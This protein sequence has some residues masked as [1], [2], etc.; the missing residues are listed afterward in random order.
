MIALRR[1]DAPAGNESRLEF[2][3]AVASPED[4]ALNLA[5]VKEGSAGGQGRDDHAIK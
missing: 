4:S 3:G 2:G 5:L 1:L